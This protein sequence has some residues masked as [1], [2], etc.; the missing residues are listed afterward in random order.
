MFKEI[1]DF[2]ISQD[3]K[4]IGFKLFKS[5]KEWLEIVGNHWKSLEIIGNR[6]KSSKFFELR[7]V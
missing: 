3:N 5:L 2:K 6:W 1:L 7:V 4:I